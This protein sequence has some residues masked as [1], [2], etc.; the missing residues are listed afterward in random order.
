MGKLGPDWPKL[1][2]FLGVPEHI[3]AQVQEE[4]SLGRKVMALLK[5]WRAHSRAATRTQLAECLRRTDSR[6]HR[7]ADMLLI[8]SNQE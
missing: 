1:Q 4:Q 5:A 7:A 8:S 6:L 3:M 2:S